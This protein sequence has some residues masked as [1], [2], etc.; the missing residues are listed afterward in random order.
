MDKQEILVIHLG[1]LGDICLSESVFHSLR[2]QFGNDLVALGNRRF[3]SLFNNYFLRVEGLESRKW[4]YLF[5]EKLNGPVWRRVVFIGKD[6]EGILRKRWQSFS[7]DE[8]VFIDMYPEGAFNETTGGGFPQKNL[9]RRLHIE[10]YQLLQLEK[11]GI[12]PLKRLI[13]EKKS[14]RVILYPERGFMKEKW[15]HDNFL[16]L[17]RSL[18]QKGVNVIVQQPSGL[19]F[20]VTRKI[21]HEDLTEIQQFYS[22]GGVFVSNDSGMAHLAGA[23]GLLT[24]TIFTD[25]DPFIWHPRGHH[26]TFIHRDTPVSMVMAERKILEILEDPHAALTLF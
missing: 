10:D 17:Y 25:F 22:D 7:E 3:I 21:S 13:E 15:H 20:D 12:K 16:V 23:C 6:L 18:E 11:N 24:I 1:G 26:F 19:D 4:L 9:E 14:D 2:T 8:I 5:S